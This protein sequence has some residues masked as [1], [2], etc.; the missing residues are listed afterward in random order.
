LEVLG[1]LNFQE[2]TA[3]PHH[4]QLKRERGKIYGA[5]RG[6]DHGASDLLN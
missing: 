2:S 4:L 5:I 3:T 1:G 6:G